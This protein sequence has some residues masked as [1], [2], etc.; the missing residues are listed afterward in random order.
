M[1]RTR[2]AHGS[3]E[4]P[5]VGRDIISFYCYVSQIAADCVNAP[6]NY[7]CGRKGKPWVSMD[8]IGL[9]RSVEES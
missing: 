7:E 9:Q 6:V 2:V 4:R 3:D 8:A 1:A 5:S